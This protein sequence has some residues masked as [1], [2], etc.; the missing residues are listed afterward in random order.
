MTIADK[1]SINE[2]PKESPSSDA[3]RQEIFSNSS[4]F[5]MQDAVPS[6]RNRGAEQPLPNLTIAGLEAGT[7]SYVQLSMPKEIP[8]GTIKELPVKPVAVVEQDQ[9]RATE[10][11]IKPLP[12]E[13]RKQR[14]RWGLSE[15]DRY[16]NLRD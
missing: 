13:I 9:P 4:T 14:E 2:Q 3:F 6:Y 16:W 12:E 11:P 8:G 15:K 7:Q 1:F 5:A 10:L